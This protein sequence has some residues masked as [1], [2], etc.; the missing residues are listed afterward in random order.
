MWV[1][2]GVLVIATVIF[3]KLIRPLK[4]V[5]FFCLNILVTGW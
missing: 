4:Q 1:F 3:V 2:V 5:G